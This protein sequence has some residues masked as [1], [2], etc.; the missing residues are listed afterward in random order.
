MEVQ[1]ADTFTKSL[2]RLRWHNS[3]IYRSYS[4]FRYDIPRFIANVWRFRK[5]LNDHYWWSQLGV[6][7]FMK[8]G[9]NHMAENIEVRGNEVDHSRLKK[10]A[11][12]KRAVVL[13]DHMMLDNYTELAEAE[14]GEI[15][16]HDFEF[17]DVPDM[18]GYSRLMDNSTEEEKSHADKVY[19]RSVEIE[20]SENIELWNILR[21]QD[22]AN[23]EEE[24]EYDKF[25]DGS[26]IRGWWD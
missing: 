22:L 17:E 4:L 14:L 12:M 23:I 13:L 16:R 15:K 1:F 9:L 2:K 26:G 11:A 20:K 25:F 6:L 24:E 19:A 7:T 21:G 10:V 8:T 3:R 18:P 5:A